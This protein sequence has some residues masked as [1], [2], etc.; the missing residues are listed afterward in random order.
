MEREEKTTIFL[1]TLSVYNFGMVHWVI[2]SCKWQV[3][4]P[5]TF[6]TAT[7]LV[8]TSI[9]RRRNPMRVR[10]EG[11]R[12]AT[13]RAGR[14]CIYV[15]IVCVHVVLSGK[16]KCL[17]PS[18]G[19]TAPSDHDRFDC[20]FNERGQDCACLLGR[21]GGRHSGYS[22]STDRCRREAFCDAQR[23][24]PW[25]SAWSSALACF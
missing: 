7:S 12:A 4:N 22:D 5:G 10:G 8:R 2:H 24:L 13:P 14:I 1:C 15:R 21:P 18:A 16:K 9:M 25:S 17:L 23:I 19:W 11:C 3:E 20:D 6:P